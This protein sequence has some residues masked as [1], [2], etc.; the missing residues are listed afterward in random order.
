MSQHA[1]VS[2]RM[3]VSCVKKIACGVCA[4]ENPEVVVMARMSFND[5]S[6]THACNANGAT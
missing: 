4:W 5:V 1:C 2:V 3:R 6:A